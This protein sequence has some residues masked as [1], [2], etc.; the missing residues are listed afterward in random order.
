MSFGEDIAGRLSSLAKPTKSKVDKEPMKKFADNTGPIKEEAGGLAWMTLSSESTSNTA[1]KIPSRI[2]KRLQQNI[3]N[4]GKLLAEK[5]AQLHVAPR[6]KHRKA[7]GQRKVIK[8]RGTKPNRSKRKKN[9]QA[10]TQIKKGPGLFVPHQNKL[11]FKK[12]RHGRENP[13]PDHAR[14]N[15]SSTAQKPPTRKVVAGA[16]ADNVST[17]IKKKESTPDN[18]RLAEGLLQEP[19]LDSPTVAGVN[20]NTFQ[21]AASVHEV[22]TCPTR[23]TTP[24][25]HAKRATSSATTQQGR[26]TGTFDGRD[27]KD[28]RI[29]HI[30]HHHHFVADSELKQFLAGLS[31]VYAKSAQ[32]FESAVAHA[33]V[34]PASIDRSDDALLED[35][36]GISEQEQRPAMTSGLSALDRLTSKVA[37]RVAQKRSVPWRSGESVRSPQS[38][39][40]E[41]MAE[42]WTTPP[43]LSAGEVARFQKSTGIVFPMTDTQGYTSLDQKGS[44]STGQETGTERK[45]INGLEWPLVVAQFHL[46]ASQSEFEGPSHLDVSSG[47]PEFDFVKRLFLQSEV[48]STPKNVLRIDHRPSQ[49]FATQWWGHDG[50]PQPLGVFYFFGEQWQDLA[51]IA[52]QGMSGFMK[53][54]DMEPRDAMYCFGSNLSAAKH[55]LQ[56]YGGKP[57]SHSS[58]V[59]VAGI[60]IASQEQ[61]SELEVGD[62]EAGVLAKVSAAVSASRAT[63][64]VAVKALNTQ[65]VCLFVP[66]QFLSNVLPLYLVELDND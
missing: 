55:A 22:G 1:P 9:A 51:L 26:E 57:I 48:T 43:K 4:K 38:R 12:R 21:Q 17:L 18:L 40:V 53:A 36:T 46:N 11:N 49:Q 24:S 37:Q 15:L 25:K 35:E 58:R 61:I 44:K 32:P 63:Q 2:M 59:L 13:R 42:E 8:V 14:A 45:P 6:Q 7:T 3:V 28:Q 41:F 52:E 23:I 64:A 39:R 47:L 19:N 5:N 29:H 34:S 54:R 27:I 10:G 60:P 66:Q 33:V 16:P 31:G 50:E 30:H 20:N 62:L 65:E 56:L